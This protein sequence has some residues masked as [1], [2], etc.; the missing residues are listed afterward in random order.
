MVCMV[1]LLLG[2]DVLVVMGFE[3]CGFHVCGLWY[4]DV[5]CFFGLDAWYIEDV[6]FV[7]IDDENILLHS[8]VCFNNWIQA[9]NLC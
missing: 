3:I 9:P 1:R 6:L 5:F 4:L 8:V 2:M 7:V